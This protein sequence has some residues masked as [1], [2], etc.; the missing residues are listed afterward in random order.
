MMMK[1][2]PID[3][4]NYSPLF[5]VVKSHFYVES[6]NG[7][8]D[9]EWFKMRKHILPVNEVLCNDESMLIE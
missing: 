5:C 6:E 4:V 9:G 8:H 2:V 7:E 1:L 3:S